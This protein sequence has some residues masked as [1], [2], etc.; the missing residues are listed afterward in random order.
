MILVLLSSHQALIAK[1]VQSITSHCPEEQKVFIR[2][3]PGKEGP[4]KLRTRTTKT[5]PCSPN[6]HL[7]RSRRK[8]FKCHVQGERNLFKTNGPRKRRY[9][10]NEVTTNRVVQSRCVVK[11][12]L[13]SPF[14]DMDASLLIR[15]KGK[16][17]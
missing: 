6:L 10:R 5:E 1:K 12:K 8:K 7:P 14:G 16:M 3:P 11:C 4:L 13:V 9:L 15:T 2:L 17:L